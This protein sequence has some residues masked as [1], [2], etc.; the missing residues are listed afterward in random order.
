MKAFLKKSIWQRPTLPPSR[1][2][3]TIGAE[4]LNFRV[5]NG[6]GCD[7]LAKA[8]KKLYIVKCEEL[9]VRCYT[10]HLTLHASHL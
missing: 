7:P 1:P 3:S 2:G 9:G 8:T 6:N 10:L 5:R 4:G